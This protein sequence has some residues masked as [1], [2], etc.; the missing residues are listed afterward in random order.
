[1]FKNPEIAKLRM[2][3]AEQRRINARLRQYAPQP[4]GA[5]RILDQALEDALK[6]VDLRSEGF[7]TRLQDALGYMS[8]RRF[9]Y[10][11]ALLKSARIV[12][13]G[14]RGEPYRWR[15]LPVAQMQL[16]ATREHE[17]LLTRGAALLLEHTPKSVREN[18]RSLSPTGY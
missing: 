8:R 12:C 10:A 7:G 1:M 9:A 5:R 18:V 6:L 17:L 15:G 11:I 13:G 16:L 3:L 4:A 2:Q 14:G